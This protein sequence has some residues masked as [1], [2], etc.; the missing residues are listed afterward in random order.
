MFYHWCSAM[1]LKWA[2]SLQ[3]HTDWLLLCSFI[4]TLFILCA[5]TFI[6]SFWVQYPLWQS[7]YG[8]GG[9]WGGTSWSW[10]HKHVRDLISK[11]NLTVSCYCLILH[12]LEIFRGQLQ[13]SK[14]KVRVKNLFH[15]T[16]KIKCN[17]RTLYLIGLSCSLWCV[18]LSVCFCLLSGEES[19]VCNIRE[20]DGERRR[21]REQNE[22]HKTA[23]LICYRA[24][25]QYFSFIGFS[26]KLSFRGGWWTI[27]VAFV[28]LM[29]L[30]FHF[31][32]PISHSS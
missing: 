28:N 15:R 20:T 2:H 25:F 32:Y 18:E 1:L 8:F 17:F 5:T 24:G 31:N 9:T 6:L 23:T 26:Q 3:L 14:I 11:V 7:I 30:Q 13:L 16:L 29:S 10:I 27:V 21:M 22:H 4:T 19:A 12:Q